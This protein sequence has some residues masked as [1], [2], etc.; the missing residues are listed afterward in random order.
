[1]TAPIIRTPNP[2]INVNLN[3]V[4][5]SSIDKLE[6]SLISKLK[7]V[8][9]NENITIGRNQPSDYFE[10]LINKLYGKYGRQ[11]AALVD[12][13]DAP[14]LSKLT[15]TD[16]A[17]QI[18]ETLGKFHSVMKSAEEH[19]S[20][21]FITGVA[22]FTK[23]SVFSSLNNLRDPTLDARYASICGFILEEF[24]SLFADR[25]PLAPDEAESNGDLKRNA[26]E[27]DLINKKSLTGTTAVPGAGS[28]VF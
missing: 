6:G 3:T 19:R 1:M 7:I 27:E 26:T 14:I 17:D 22:R 10:A 25:L 21:T 16:L 18:R 20:F 9:E 12:E 15:E 4:S 13:Y 28:P 11:V 2:V 23:A 8:A 24:D 5:A